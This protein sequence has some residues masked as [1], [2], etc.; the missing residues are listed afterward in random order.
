[1]RRPKRTVSQPRQTE[2]T[3]IDVMRDMLDELRKIH[4][5]RFRLDMGTVDR[6]EKDRKHAR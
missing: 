2:G 4:Y 5:A 1:M 6:L 3:H